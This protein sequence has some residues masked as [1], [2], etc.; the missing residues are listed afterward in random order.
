M[1]EASFFLAQCPMEK[2]N[3]AK[4]PEALTGA[5]QRQSPKLSS[6][7]PALPCARLT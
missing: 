5:R 6:L 1:S 7:F 3:F 2:R 4:S